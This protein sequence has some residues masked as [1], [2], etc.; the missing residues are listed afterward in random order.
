MIEASAL[1]T[2]D[3]EP[4]LSPFKTLH[5]PKPLTL[6]PKA[7]ERPGCFSSKTPCLL[8]GGF[9]FNKFVSCHNTGRITGSP[10]SSAR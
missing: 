8:G 6:N 10:A 7:S 3:P 5:A 4:S 9:L 2:L 1:T